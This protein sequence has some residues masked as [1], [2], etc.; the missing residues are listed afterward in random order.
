MD[1]GTSTDPQAAPRADSLIRFT[2][3]S[4]FASAVGVAAAVLVDGLGLALAGLIAGRSPVLYHNEVVFTAAGSDLALGGGMVLSLLAGGF[5]LS[6]YPGSGRYDAAR[7][8]MLWVVL[9]CFRQGF[10]QLATV[11][12]TEDSGVARAFATLD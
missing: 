10:T 3:T 1:T 9:H 6:L 8:T 2:L 4:A 5:F 11:P 7:L 12:L